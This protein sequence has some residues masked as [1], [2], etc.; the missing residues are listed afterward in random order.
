MTTTVTVE[1]HCDANTEVLVTENN[2]GTYGGDLREV[3]LQNGD[4]FV[5][6]TY[7]NKSVT[8]KERAKK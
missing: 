6:H 8:V 3:V 7:S 4:R 1:A 5:T 2:M